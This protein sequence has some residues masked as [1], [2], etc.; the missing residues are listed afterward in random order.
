MHKGEKIED[1]D[2]EKEKE[3]KSKDRQNELVALSN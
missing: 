3:E 2:K 1:K